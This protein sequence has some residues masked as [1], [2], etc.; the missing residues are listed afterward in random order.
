MNDLF[1]H[2]FSIHGPYMLQGELMKSDVI[3]IR[4]TRF[5]QGPGWKFHKDIER[6]GRK[7]LLR[8]LG[9]I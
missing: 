7:T 2:S 8:A 6:Q 3:T 5:K 1:N 4:V 9:E